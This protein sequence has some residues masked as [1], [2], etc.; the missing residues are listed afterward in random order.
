M[1]TETAARLRRLPRIRRARG[2]RLSTLDGRRLL[3]MWQDGGRAI[4]G[5]RGAD[6]PTALK[7]ALDRGVTEAFPSAQEHRLEQALRRLLGDAEPF[8]LAVYASRERAY[9]AVSRSLGLAPGRLVVGDPATGRACDHEPRVALWRPFLPGDPWRVADGGADS[10]HG[11][12]GPAAGAR[13]AVLLPVLPC[14]G[15]VD[16]QVVLAARD[17]HIGLESDLLPEASLVAL[18]VAA[19]ALVSAPSPPVVA[20]P[21]F[22]VRGPYCVPVG[23]RGG[24]YDALFDRFLEAGIVLSPDPA[25]PSI[26]PGELSDG[27][28]RLI[29][30][31]AS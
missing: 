9:A 19:D 2:Y 29:E 10:G 24:D 11:G 22:D 8:S 5:H 16:A 1:P 28:R 17:A 3:D 27:E 7:R 15:L 23:A 14:G 4:L 30:R 31:T 13:A 20:L 25:L 21:G 12:G 26:V 6:V 18:T